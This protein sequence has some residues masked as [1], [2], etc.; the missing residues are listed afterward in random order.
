MLRR[1]R[2]DVL[3]FLVVL[4]G[5]LRG[6]LSARPPGASWAPAP[7]L[8]SKPLAPLNIQAQVHHVALEP[9]AWVLQT[10]EVC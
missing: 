10:P 2:R 9:V 4:P 5:F 1:R 7:I 3:G 8:A 6:P